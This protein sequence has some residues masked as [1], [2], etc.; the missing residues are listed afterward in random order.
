MASMYQDPKILRELFRSLAHR[1]TVIRSGWNTY[2][3]ASLDRVCYDHVSPSSLPSHGRRLPDS[4]GVCVDDEFMATCPRPE[5]GRNVHAEEMILKWLQSRIYTSK[6]PPSDGEVHTLHLFTFFSPCSRCIERLEDFLLL[7]QKKGLMGRI[8]FVLG[9]SKEYTPWKGIG[10]YVT[11]PWLN[12]IA[13]HYYP[14]FRVMKINKYNQSKRV[15]I[16]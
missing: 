11:I 10:P 7:L 15:D 9:Y 3:A 16:Y 6:W 13:Q 2:A 14:N 1:Y 5:V 4:F 12:R 8:R